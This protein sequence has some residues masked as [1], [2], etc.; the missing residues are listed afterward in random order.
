[1]A[2]IADIE[3]LVEKRLEKERENL[4]ANALLFVPGESIEYYCEIIFSR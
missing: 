4:E 3:E 1:M 2:S